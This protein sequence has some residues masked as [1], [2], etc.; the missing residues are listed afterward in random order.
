MKYLILI[1]FFVCKFSCFANIQDACLQQEMNALKGTKNPE[2]DPAIDYLIVLSG[3]NSYLQKSSKHSLDSADDYNRMQLALQT[4]KKIAALRAKIGLG[5]VGP[6]VFEQYGPYIVYNGSE[7]QNRDLKCALEQGL[8]GYPKDKFLILKTSEQEMNTKGQFQSL[9]LHLKIEN[10]A[11]AIVT[12]AYHFPRISRMLSETAP[13]YPFGHNVKKYAFLVDREFSSKGIDVHVNKE[14]QNIPIYQEKGDLSE[15][16]AC[17]VIYI[18][19]AVMF[20]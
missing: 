8:M 15:N 3:A 17:D 4:A 1:F 7:S 10:T 19:N 9:K 16:P 12:H 6:A 14:I 2:V 18:D 13:L 5:V 20:N 11:V